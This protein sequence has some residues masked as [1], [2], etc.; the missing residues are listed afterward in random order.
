MYALAQAA[1]L[2]I[3]ISAPEGTTAGHVEQATT[4]AVGPGGD[5]WTAGDDGTKMWTKENAPAQSKGGLEKTSDARS[6]STEF[7]PTD[8]LVGHGGGVLALA[9][10]PNGAVISGSTDRTAKIWSNTT[11]PVGCRGTLKGHGG[12]V[13]AVVVCGINTTIYTASDDCS[14]VAWRRSADNFVPQR[15]TGHTDRINA[16]ALGADGTLYS[17][18]DDST[19]R[20]WSGSDGHLLRTLTGH[21]EPVWDVMAASN[22]L[23]YTAAD[24]TLIHVW[25]AITGKHLRVLEGHTGGVHRVVETR[26]GAVVSSSDDWPNDPTIRVWNPDTGLAMCTI[27]ITV[28]A[29]TVPGGSAP[30]NV[31][32]LASGQDGKLY[33][34]SAKAGSQQH[35]LIF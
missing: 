6:T 34:L 20:V 3:S 9:V 35:V 14:I 22:G 33:A 32:A 27:P 30:A 16:L 21:S 13:R 12:A 11:S 15:L 24:D 28:P 17:A 19:V 2:Y 10:G 7:H 29:A 26:D 4:L 1:P 18:S 8:V 25:D 5:V 31:V 23:V